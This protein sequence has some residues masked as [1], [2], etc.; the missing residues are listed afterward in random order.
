MSEPGMPEAEEARGLFHPAGRAYRFTVL[1]FVGFII[2]GSYFA[3]D[4]IGAIADSLMPALGIGQRQI[5]I[6]YSMYSFGPMLFLFLAG[7]L[8]DRMG[9]R[10]ASLVFTGLITLGAVVVAI[11]S[12]IWPMYVGRFVFGFGSEAALVAQNAIL[13]RWFR[14]KELALAFGVALTISRL[15]T[16]F[17]F[18][19]E[20]LI[21]ERLGPSAALWVAAGLCGA[22][23]LANLVYV[24]MDRHAERVLRLTEEQAGDRIVLGEI[25]KLG[26]PFWMVTALCFTFYS[27]IFPF[28][29]L[30]TNFFHE[31]W[32]LPLT[33]GSGGGFFAEVFSSFL[34]MF[35]TAPGTTSIIIFASMVFAPFAGGLV[36]RIGR[37]GSLMIGG[38]LLMIPC[39]LALGFT[40]MTPQGPMVLL[41]AA[42]VLV[43]AAMWPSVPLVVDKRVTGTAY[44][45]MTQLQNIGLFLFP[46]VNGGLREATGGYQASMMMFAS[47]GILGVV[48]AVLL[49]RF[50]HAAGGVL[51]RP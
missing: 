15:G 43:P 41:G 26:A 3:Y 47:L 4:S 33:A 28:T 48:C 11:S 14:G 25:K 49:R 45:V 24:L 34:H 35:T 8:I 2:Y 19:T 32:G 40:H 10:V 44:G 50:D 9:T 30:S 21:A 7:F 36:D 29:A 18:N 38:S 22:S 42:F 46:F 27:A 5:G 17:S 12:S 37:R 51:E 1:L 20:A 16:L 23:M 13:V 31:K 6:L 39:Y